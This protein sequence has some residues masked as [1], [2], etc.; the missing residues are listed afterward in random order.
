MRNVFSV[1]DVEWPRSRTN[2]RSFI[3]VVRCGDGPLPPELCRFART[4]GLRLPS[5]ARGG[6]LQTPSS[7][8]NRRWAVR[9][10]PSVSGLVSG[11]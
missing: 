10:R 2:W 3:F 4:V 1:P 6:Q 11:W 9:L 5:V 8:A 7:R